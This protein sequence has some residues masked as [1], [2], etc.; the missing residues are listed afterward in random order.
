GSAPRAAVPGASSG[1]SA[2]SAHRPASVKRVSRPTPHRPSASPAASDAP[3][4]PS[5]VTAPRPVTATCRTAGLLLVPLGHDEVDEGLH[6]GKGA[7]AH[8]LVR[9]GDAE[10][11][12]DEHH[13]LEGIDGV[14]A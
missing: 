3:S 13:E 11:V 4:P 5:A 14:E 12:L 2:A 6:R 1:T 7:L 9:D 8:F 10:A